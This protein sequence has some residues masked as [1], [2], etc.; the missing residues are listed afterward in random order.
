MIRFWDSK[1]GGA[2]PLL[3]LAGAPRHGVV[4]P[5]PRREKWSVRLLGRRT[6]LKAK[7]GGESSMSAKAGDIE[8]V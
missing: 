8:T 7:A 3:S 6:Y 5:R 4:D 2:P 1:F